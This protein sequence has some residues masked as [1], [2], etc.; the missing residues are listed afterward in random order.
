[1]PGEVQIGY[2]EKILL[3]KS[4][5]ALEQAAWEGGGVTAPGGV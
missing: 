2:Y 1:M 5:D 3:K 4:D